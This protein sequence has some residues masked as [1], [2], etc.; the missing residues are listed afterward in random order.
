M[1]NKTPKCKG[2]PNQIYCNFAFPKNNIFVMGLC[3]INGDS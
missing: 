2:L 3:S 1:M